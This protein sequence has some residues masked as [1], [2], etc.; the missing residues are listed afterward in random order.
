MFGF[1]DVIGR[2]Q[3]QGLGEDAKRTGIE[4]NRIR[5]PLARAGAQSGEDA[6]ADVVEGFGIAQRRHVE[7]A[8]QF[9]R[10]TL[11]FVDRG[12][13]RADVGPLRDRSEVERVGAVFLLQVAIAGL[14]DRGGGVVV[15][16]SG[17]VDEFRADR[18]AAQIVDAGAVGIQID[19][20]QAADDGGGFRV[21]E[22]QRDARRV[23]AARRDDGRLT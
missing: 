5:D 2:I 12:Q 7:T 23:R 18:R 22:G 15:D 17:D 3:R 4:R 13:V 14:L 11:G 8:A 6:E 16:G 9:V 1:R 20:H 10:R 21:G 19:R